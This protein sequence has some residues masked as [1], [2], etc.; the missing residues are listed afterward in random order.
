MGVGG[1][2]GRRGGWVGEGRGGGEVRKLSTC[3]QDPVA[4]WANLLHQPLLTLPGFRAN[5]INK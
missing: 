4:M 5:A 2:G 1:V 3:T